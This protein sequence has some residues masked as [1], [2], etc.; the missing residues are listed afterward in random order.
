[1]ATITAE[2]GQGAPRADRR[3]LHGLQARARGERTAT[4]TRPSPCSASAASRRPPRSPVARPAKASSRSYIHTGGRVGVLIEV[5]CETDFV[6]RTDEFQ[7]L[8]RDLAIQVAGHEPRCTS[9]PTRSR[10]TSSTAKKA[11]LLARRVASRRSPRTIREQIVEGQLK[12]WFTEVCLLD[13]PFRDDG[14]LG[15]RADHREDRDDRREHPRP[16]LRPLR[17][18]GGAVSDARLG[19]RPTSAAG[20][21]GPLPAD[22]AQ[23]VRRGAPRRSPVRRRPGVLR[24][25]SPAR[26]RRSTRLGVQIGI[27]VGGGNI[28]RGLAAAA[29]GHGPR[30][31]RLH[32]HARDRDE[33]PGPPGRARA[34]RRARP[35]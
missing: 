32:R 16:A 8:V 5:N 25:R 4:S 9:T 30:D 31:R 18:R 27:V 35:G 34:G 21:A 1:M 29:S 3:R 7:K 26:S 10:P 22:P 12:K 14:A 23:A 19:G 2:R 15:P 6:A 11:E 33:R 17:A 28:F 20:R 13:Q 24:V